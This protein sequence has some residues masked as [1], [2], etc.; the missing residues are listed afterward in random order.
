MIGYPIILVGLAYEVY[1]ST[2]D[3]RL[4]RDRKGIFAG[5]F[6]ITVAVVII[7]V[8]MVWKPYD[9]EYSIFG[10]M[11]LEFPRDSGQLYAMPN[12]LWDFLSSFCMETCS[13]SL[14]F[15]ILFMT[16]STPQRSGSYKIMLIGAIVFESLLCMLTYFLFFF[17]NMPVGPY[18]GMT[19]M[20]LR[21]IGEERN[22]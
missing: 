6:L 2:F 11:V 4:S 13:F 5:I 8:D 7:W 21:L 12:L 3:L 15:G 14:M 9:P 10:S 18:V 17:L 20:E 19:K 22:S 16:R 1:K